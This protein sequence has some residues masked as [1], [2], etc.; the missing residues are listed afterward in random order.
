MAEPG[1]DAK[2]PA[3]SGMREDGDRDSTV[4][5]RGNLKIARGPYPLKIHEYQA[6]AILA[7]YGV[8]VPKGE[9]A[10]TLEEANDVAREKYSGDDAGDAPDRPAGTKGAAAAHRGDR[11]H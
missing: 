7:K 2:T 4:N 1:L 5:L 11:G 10:N 9:M 8:P 3:A 6:K